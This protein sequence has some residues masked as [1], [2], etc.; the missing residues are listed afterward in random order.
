MLSLRWSSAHADRFRGVL[1]ACVLGNSSGF[2]LSSLL[3]LAPLVLV[4]FVAGLY[5]GTRFVQS[6]VTDTA[7]PADNPAIHVQATTH[8]IVDS[9]APSTT[10]DY[11][12]SEE[13]IHVSNQPATS[14]V[15][16]FDVQKN[17]G[18]IERALSPYFPTK[19]GTFMTAADSFDGEDTMIA[20]WFYL[21]PQDKTGSMKTVFG[22]KG[23]G[24]DINPT[25]HGY[26]VYVNGW[27]TT[28]HWLY[29]EWGGQMSGC[30]KISSESADVQVKPGTWN[31]VALVLGSN[32]VTLFLNGEEVC[33]SHLV[34]VLHDEN[35]INTLPPP[36]MLFVCDFLACCCFSG[37][38]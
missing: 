31:H 30:H 16:R 34:I 21:D 32:T 18:L 24:C 28:D 20:A 1:I 26:A 15:D 11:K 35:I 13:P 36:L 27:E 5:V 38:H 33:T 9:L 17:Y 12:K 7:L 10:V 14:K 22:N 3:L 4:F 19:A 8:Q 29:A 25:Q 6:H 2:S 37:R 23:P